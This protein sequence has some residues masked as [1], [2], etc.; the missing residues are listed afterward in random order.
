[1]KKYSKPSI[2]TIALHHRTV[3]LDVSPNGYQ[4]L[5]GRSM[6]SPGVSNSYD[7]GTNGDEYY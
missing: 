5:R 3:L 2:R 1:M 6:S 4:N 7:A